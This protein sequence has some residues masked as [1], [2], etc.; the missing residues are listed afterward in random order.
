[1]G[2]QKGGKLLLAGVRG[3][4]ILSEEFHLLSYAPTN[5][6]VI[7]VQAGR[8]ALAIEDL[9]PNVVLD[10]TLQFLLGRRTS[11]RAGK[12]LREGRDARRGDDDFGGSLCFV[13]L[14]EHAE[15]AEEG[16]P[17]QEELEQRLP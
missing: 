11:P 10:K 13:L 8:S 14:A 12:A 7:S 3:R 17:E 6:D 1:M 15:E 5:D 2:C 16:R 9:L 4:Y